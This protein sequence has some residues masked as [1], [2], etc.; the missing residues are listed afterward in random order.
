MSMNK[1]FAHIFEMGEF[2]FKYA[3]GMRD[4]IGKEIHNYHEIFF[5]L[6]GNAMFISEKGKIILHPNTAVIIPR[7]TFHQFTVLGS[8]SDY[9][10]CVYNFT[11]VNELDDMISQ[12]LK[13]IKIVSEP[14][15]TEIFTELRDLA[16][17]NINDAERRILLKAHLGRILVALKQSRE[18]PHTYGVFSPITRKVIETI[19]ADL[20]GD[21]TSRTIAK[22]LGISVSHLQHVF[23]SDVQVPLHRYVLEK[24]L[25]YASQL[26]SLGASAT[27]ASINCGF[28][29]YSGF[30]KQYKKY[31]GVSPSFHK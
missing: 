25:A 10:R 28:G 15:I 16:T 11:E 13:N 19:A 1:E 21:L 12:T 30:Y 23:K 4:I 22:A 26:I 14:H 2:R 24:R 3:K 20:T 6:S 5:F 8:E 29:D 18:S 31:Y 9:M 27:E 17:E 7:D